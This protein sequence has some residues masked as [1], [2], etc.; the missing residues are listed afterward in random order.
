MPSIT[1]YK[2]YHILSYGSFLGATLFQ[3]FIGG[4]V[5]FK[6]LPRAQFS[7]LQKATF[8]IFFALQSVLGLTLMVTYP[9]EKLLGVGGQYIRENVG[10]RGLLVD[11]NRWPVFVPLATIFVTSVLNS[12]II[13]PAT[14]KTMKDR[15]HQETRDGKKY[16][17]PGPHSKAMEQLNKTFGMLHEYP[18]GDKFDPEYKTFFE[19]FYE[20]SDTPTAH[21]EY[22]KQFTQDATLIMASKNVQGR[23]DYGLKDGREVTVDWAARAH[24]VKHNGAVMMDFYQVYLDTAAQNPSK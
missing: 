10:W 3:S 17:D 8:P 12:L 14:T 6:V 18:A 7:T 15:H 21:E 22:S 24:L 4:V 11:S 23:E 20:T 19:K 2:A 5:A 16:S 9:G 1:D 13:G